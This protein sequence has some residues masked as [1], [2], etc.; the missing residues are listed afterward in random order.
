MAKRTEFQIKNAKRKRH[1]AHVD[2][3]AGGMA[4][5]L[6]AYLL[7]VSTKF[8]S[9]T[10]VAIYASYLG[11]FSIVLLVLYKMM[12]FYDAEGELKDNSVLAIVFSVGLTSGLLAYVCILGSINKWLAALAMLT[13]CLGLLPFTWSF[14]SKT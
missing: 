2:G 11:T 3:I 12:S 1:I 10:G 5:I 9:L 8:V 6:S 14:K 7:A 4:A 13:F